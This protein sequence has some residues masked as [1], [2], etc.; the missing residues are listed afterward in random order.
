MGSLSSGSFRLL[1]RGN[2]QFADPV[3]QHL[4]AP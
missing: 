4:G 1:V 3:P 2:K